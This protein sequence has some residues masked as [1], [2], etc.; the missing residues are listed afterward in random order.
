[1]N[2]PVSLAIHR[3]KMAYDR[4]QKLAQLAFAAAL[5]NAYELWQSVPEHYAAARHVGP[6]ETALLKCRLQLPLRERECKE[7]RDL[8][9]GWLNQQP[10][11]IL[12][13]KITTCL[14][15]LTEDGKY[16]MGYGKVIEFRGRTSR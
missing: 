3:Q 4:K 14:Q 5:T 11:P 16:L 15:C 10:E 6:L 7:V 9:L 8:L 2:A 13:E 12:A 1:M